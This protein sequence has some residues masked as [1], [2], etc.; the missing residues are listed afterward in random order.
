MPASSLDTFFACSL[1]VILIV[2][3]MVGTAKVVQ[4]YLNDLANV[5]G[6]ERY[7]GLAEYLLLSAG[8]PSDWG[9]MVNDVPTVFGLASE[10]RQSYE[11]DL[12][13]VCRLNSDNIYS[14]NYQDI[15]T[16]LV[17]DVSLNIKIRPLFEIS[18]NLASSQSGENETTYIF[19]IST[20]KSGFPIPTWLR[21]YTVVETYISNVSSS[22]DSNGAGTVNVVLP[23][24]FNGTALFVVFA[25]AKAYSQMIGFNVYSF[26]HNSEALES[27]KTF[28]QLSPLNHVLN[29]SFQYAT[30][31]LSNAY[32]FTYNYYFSLSQ[33]YME[34]Q[35]VEYY[36]PHLLEA[37]PMMLMLNGN[38][39]SSTSFAEWT[40]YPQLP[41]EIGANFNDLTAK[42][43]AVAL[44]Y[45]VG[46]NS[47]LYEAVI[48][49]RSV[50]N[51]N[52]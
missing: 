52:A 23:N 8:S 48:T 20:S 28:L 35:T 5:N 37:S 30:V 2:S 3:A 25:K 49:C 39:A 12:D 29:V 47:V 33:T 31:E 42:S 7:R 10:T 11:L 14:I 40:A 45:V 36:I 22:T 18:I 27:N 4:P 34:N 32:V 6:I 51:Y 50:R 1:M 46:V 26:G 17:E 21:C 43:K 41:L 15:L 9:V 38:N 16:A 19:Q 13:K 44:T 24:S